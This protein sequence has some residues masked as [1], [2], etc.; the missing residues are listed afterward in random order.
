MV[1]RIILNRRCNLAADHNPSTHFHPMKIRAVSLLCFLAFAGIPDTQAAVVVSNLNEQTLNNDGWAVFSNHWTGMSFTVG[2]TSPLWNLDSVDIRA[3]RGG[4]GNGFNVALHEDAGGLP[5]APIVILLGP[6]P[7]DSPIVDN[8]NYSPTVPTALNAGATYW[9]TG[10]SIT[11][12]FAWVFTDPLSTNDTG[13]DGWGIG[14][15]VAFSTDQG[16]IWEARSDEPSMFAVHATAIPEPLVNLSSGVAA[17]CLLVRRRR[18]CGE[19]PG[20]GAPS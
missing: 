8:Y 13:T 1:K 15:N 6:D 4:G 3:F 10:T 20:T 11:G 2:N 12:N 7:Q 16:V 19:I 5:G 17:A 18:N 9:I 14:D